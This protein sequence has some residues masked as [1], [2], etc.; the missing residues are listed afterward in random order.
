M[1]LRPA[2]AEDAA[3]IAHIFHDAVMRG[4]AQEYSLE[5]RRAWAGP[6]PNPEGWRARIVSQS[7]LVADVQGHPCGFA[8]LAGSEFDLLFVHPDH[9][10]QGLAKALHGELLTQAK[11]AGRAKLTTFASHTARP[12]FEKQGW[13]MVRSN[14]VKRRGVVL[15]NWA[16]T[17]SI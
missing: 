1:I 7:I 14:C 4:A 10:G 12:F 8:A 9:T 17:R 2:V 5:E 6:A 3:A 16:M 11:K 15:N 13:K